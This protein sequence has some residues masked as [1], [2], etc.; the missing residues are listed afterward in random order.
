MNTTNAPQKKVKLVLSVLILVL[1]LFLYAKGVQAEEISL[2]VT[3]NGE[4]AQSEVSVQ[5][6]ESTTVQQSNNAIINN[7]VSANSNT[8]ENHVSGNGNGRADIETGNS[9]ADV[10]ITNQGIN[11]NAA[12]NSCSC[13]SNLT[14]DVSGNGSDSQNGILTDITSSS[15]TQQSNTAKITNNIKISGNT[16]NNAANN[17]V[18]DVSIKTGTI[19]S[20]VNVQN[21]GINNSQAAGASGFLST[22]VQIIG[23]GSGSTNKILITLNHDNTFIVNNLSEILSSI[24]QNLNTGGN[25]A[26]ENLGDAFIGTGDIL[27]TLK[28]VNDA[29]NSSA[30]AVDCGCKE[31]ETS[32]VKDP[33]GE[34]PNTPAGG[35]ASSSNGNSGGNGSVLG[36]SSVGEVL[37]ET[38]DYFLY[39]LTLGGFFVFLMGLYLRLHSGNSPGGGENSLR[40]SRFLTSFFLQQ[41]ISKTKNV[42]KNKTN[43]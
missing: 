9:A 37:P 43:I 1:L 39:L 13:S 29:I 24:E 25:S 20:S 4:G 32:P 8:G 21:R 6:N 26:N 15:T 38:G 40:L 2:S 11:S 42:Q 30:V 36:A 12:S 3:E 10:N 33:P 17:N 22:T 34:N 28:I 35:S 14:A 27:A 16:G 23:N 31:K 19:Y 18:G 41:I 7:D 5:S